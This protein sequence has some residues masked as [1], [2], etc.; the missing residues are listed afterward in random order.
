[1]WVWSNL[2]CD[3]VTVFLNKSGSN[4]STHTLLLVT[5]AAD[6]LALLHVCCLF[7]PCYFLLHFCKV[8]WPLS[9]SHGIF[10]TDQDVLQ[11]LLELVPALVNVR[12]QSL[13]L[14]EIMMDLDADASDVRL[15]SYTKM[16]SNFLDLDLG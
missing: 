11:A 2:W 3:K 10:S 8:A 16:L 12:D 7:C 13:D 1:M 9:L 14:D 4:S 5:S 15:R 6:V